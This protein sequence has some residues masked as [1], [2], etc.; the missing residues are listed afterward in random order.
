MKELP[1]TQLVMKLDE[2][3]VKK[4]RQKSLSA[5]KRWHVSTSWNLPN[6]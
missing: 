5:T 3:Q 2:N 6:A 1:A 4:V